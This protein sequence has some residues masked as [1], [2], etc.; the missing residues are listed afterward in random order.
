MQRIH[1]VLTLWIAL[2]A[3]P[4]SAAEPAAGYADALTE[5]QEILK[6]GD[7]KA[8]I[9]AFRQ[10]EQLAGAPA[11]DVS[12]G[13]AD[14]YN[15]AGAFADAIPS[16]RQAVTLAKSQKEQVLA[17]NLLGLCLYVGNPKGNAAQWEEA[18]A[19]FEK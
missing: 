2:L 7:P 10:A 4:A 19:S 17:Y 13:L 12:L 5:A 15:R 1:V 3:A 8:A 18:K 14:A 16:A 11:F 6:H 9:Q